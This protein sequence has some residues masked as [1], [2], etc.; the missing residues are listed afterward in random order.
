MLHSHILVLGT[1]SL[2]T[3]PVHA[4]A[5]PTDESSRAKQTHSLGCDGCDGY[6]YG[7]ESNYWY[8]DHYDHYNDY[9][10]NGD[11]YGD[12]YYDGNN[13]Y[14]EN[15]AREY[16]SAQL[17]SPTCQ[18]AASRN[19]LSQPGNVTISWNS[20]NATTGNLDN[21]VGSLI[22]AAGSVPVHIAHTTTFTSTFYGSDG[23]VSCSVTVVVRP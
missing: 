17:T 11:Y 6:G 19:S 12:N 4:Q 21:D 16:Y 20:S 3:P 1:L 8:Y 5:T 23:E 18:L 10:A 9:S 22:G 7:D 14:D 15:Y 13:Y 2:F